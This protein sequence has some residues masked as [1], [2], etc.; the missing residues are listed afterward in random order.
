MPRRR[1]VLLTRVAAAAGFALF[2]AVTLLAPQG[3][4]LARV[5]NTWGYDGLMVFACVI[6]G[7]HA[8]LVTRE[9]WAWIVI[10]VAMT[11]WTLGEI[12]AAVFKPTSYPSP[13]DL[14]FIAF[15]PLMYVGI[16]MLLRSRARTIGD[17]LWLDG[18]TSALAA[19]A[20][21]AAV[22]VELVLEQT[23]RLALHR[24]HES[25]VSA[26]RRPAAVGRVRRLRPRRRA[27][28]A[29]L[30]PARPRDPRDDAGRLDLPLPVG[31]RNVR[32]RHLGRRRC[33]P[34]RCC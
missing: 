23:V 5:M 31:E 11:C 12:W 27:S 2:T 3:G 29:A 22:L 19:G 17:T 33:G 24:H 15:Y 25:R 16:V 13:A 4:D 9:R 21:G 18:A 1:W 28:R 6:A 8:Y 34:P 26:R 14:G 10:T 20:F 7:S 30:D 32:R